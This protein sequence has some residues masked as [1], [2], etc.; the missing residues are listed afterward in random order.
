MVVATDVA[1]LLFARVVERDL[2][3][4]V[5]GGAVVTEDGLKNGVLQIA[6]LCSASVR[7]NSSLSML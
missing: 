7:G 6:S 4:V 1:G 3:V 5:V 2:R